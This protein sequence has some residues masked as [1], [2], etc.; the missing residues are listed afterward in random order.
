MSEWFVFLQNAGAGDFLLAEDPDGSVVTAFNIQYLGT[1]IILNAN[2][3][4]VYRDEVTSTYEML[5]EGMLNA[6]Q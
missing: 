1:T 5:R 4:I 2:G 3:E 6:T